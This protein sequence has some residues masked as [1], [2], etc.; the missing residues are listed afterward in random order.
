MQLVAGTDGELGEDLVQVV[1]DRARAHE[2]LGGDL[3]VGQ[4]I[5]SEPANLGLPGGELGGGLGGSFA[6]PLAGGRQLA[7]GAVG[8]CLHSERREQLVSAAQLLARIEPTVPPPQPFA[9][10][11]VG[12]GE[13]HAHATSAEPA[14]RLAVKALGCR[15]VGQQRASEPRCLAPTRCH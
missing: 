7:R 2:Q 12:A 3:G 8:E 4:A 11:E 9:V 6:D 13:R 5:P 10:Q 15:T 14:D 1:F